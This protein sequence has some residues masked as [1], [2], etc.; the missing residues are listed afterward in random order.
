MKKLTMFA[1]LSLVLVFATAA[2]AS[3]ANRALKG[4]D[5]T[6]GDYSTLTS[7]GLVGFVKSGADTVC[8]LGDDETPNRGDFQTAVGTPS[9][10]GW[11]GVDLT[12]KV[13]PIWHIDTYYADNLDPGTV[14]NHAWWCGEMWDS[15]GPTDP[16]GGYGNNYNEYLDWWG[17]V[18]DAG[19]PGTAR[20]EAV[21][22]YDDEPG[23]DY[24]YV[25][26][27]DATG[28]QDLMTYNGKADGVILNATHAFL[29]TDYVPH[30]DNGLP[31]IHF[32][33]NFVSDGGWSDEDC[34]WPTTGGAQV[35][36]IQVSYD[37]GGGYSQIGPT[38]D[39]EGTPTWRVTFPPGVGDFSKVWP[40]LN[41]IDPCCDNETPQ[42]AFIDD[43]LVVPGTGGY[44]CISWCYGPG[45]YI[46]NP[47]GGLAGPDFHAANE[48]WSPVLDWI[49]GYDGAE[50]E[51]SVYR[52]EQLIA[53]PSPGMFYVWH[54]RSTADPTG[55]TGWTG[56]LDRNFVYY[57]G[58]DCIRV[59][60]DVSNLM[61]PDRVKSQIALGTNELG[62]V[63]GYDGIDGTPAP[64]FDDVRFCTFVVPGPS[65]STREIDIAQDNFPEIG[66]I[67][68]GAPCDMSVRFDM[69]Q[70]ISLAAEPKNL[71]GD[72]ITFDVVPVRAGTAM[73][74]A[75]EM[76]YKMKANPLFNSCR[77]TGLP[78][79][80][81]VVGD[82]TFT[83]TGSV[84]R[85]RW[86]FD[87]P[88]TGFFFPG[89]VIHYY[90]RGTDTGMGTATLPGD[91][92]GF[93]LFPG[94]DGYV[95]LDYPS[96]YIVRALPSINDLDACTHPVVL[97]W[98]DFA[99][100]GLEPEW[101]HAFRAVG[102]TEGVDYDI[103][104]TNGPSSA[105]GDGLGGR[106]TATQIQGYNV[107]L[108]SSGDLSAYTITD[109]DYDNDA[110]NDTGVLDTW[111][112]FGDKC[113]FL[114]AND[115][116]SDLNATSGT[117]LA[118]EDTWIQVE[119]VGSDHQPL[120]GQYNPSIQAFPMAGNPVFANATR[121]AAF[122]YCVP[123]LKTFDVVNAEGSPGKI[124]EFLAAD[125]AT[126]QYG[127]AAAVETD[128]A[129]YNSKVIYLPYDL[130]YV[131]DDND[132]GGNP[133]PSIYSVRAQILRDA[134]TACGRPTTQPTIGV[135]DAAARFV[136]KQN[137]PN[138][139][140]PVTKIEYTM[141][142]DG[143]LY[144]AVYNVKGEK[145]KVL[146]DEAVKAGPGYVM[147]DG[148]N[149][150]GAAV[151][152]GV[153]FYKT[154]V[155]GKTQGIHKMALVK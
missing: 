144:I 133:V 112:Q 43:G 70:D 30:P 31:S 101:M 74:A 23:Y 69:A 119:L 128:N 110:G 57:G 124:A 66:A 108:Y 29:V 151:S 38:E 139:F 75:P 17:N 109:V 67:S 62:W 36:L 73:L 40:L 56:W 149:E 130:G 61:A 143:T 106:A 96:S 72:S 5:K 63:W 134:L 135:P 55:A 24:L 8:L 137:A 26:Y 37:Q 105:V 59:I 60:N 45:G 93:S 65:I 18:G 81:F 95:P 47:E 132:C 13:D 49:P 71:P 32:R 145:V 76:V 102:Y 68:C 7:N 77:T 11:F 153:Y 22:N 117:T 79:E 125:C 53:G 46:V 85:N 34:S 84:V 136:V 126:G 122:G 41:N 90:I 25:Q 33:F 141:P 91:T 21:L 4:Y 12:Q 104:Y 2:V 92:S 127:Y 80:G 99:N 3:D 100:R 150:S 155:N 44:S 6:V 86:N 19:S 120:L 48:I 14:P 107:L 97:W 148:T 87:L 54:V 98:N 51:F 131:G 140:N 39:C 35:D 27:E 138:P 52:H 88:D 146:R 15:C 28:M 113:A 10:D 115:L 121:W 116:V 147:W 142:S 123:N 1:C 89:D 42:F 78:N 20:I 58:P 64:Y 82:T 16:A 152:S 154:V 9:D 103:Y 83:G 118:F 94:E 50:L 114:T 111:F 129:T